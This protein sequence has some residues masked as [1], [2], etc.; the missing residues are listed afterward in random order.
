M[1]FARRQYLIGSITVLGSVVAAACDREEAPPPDATPPPPPRRA[2][3]TT[4]PTPRPGSVPIRV[5]YGLYTGLVFSEHSITMRGFDLQELKPQQELYRTTAFA[6]FQERYPD[7]HVTFETHH[8]PLPVLQAAHAADDAPDLFLA[9]DRR[10]RA[11]VRQG[12]AA[13]LDGRV[14]QW[15]DRADFVRPALAA[16]Q[17]DRQ[18]WGLPLFTQ[19]YTLYYNQALLRALGILRLPTTWEDLLAAAEQS[20]KVEGHHVVRQGINGPGPQWFMWLLQS[21]GATLYEAGQ[22]GFGGEAEAILLFLRHLHHAVHPAGVEPLH[23]ARMGQLIMY[24][25]HLWETGQLA[26]AWLPVLPRLTREE[27]GQHRSKVWDRINPEPLPNATPLPPT[28]RV[29]P[30]ELATAQALWDQAPPPEDI[31]IGRLPSP[32]KQYVIP[33]SRQVSPLIYTHSAVLHLSAQS[34]HPDPAWELLTLLLEPVTLHQYTA[35]RKAVPPRRSILGLGYL[36]NPKTQQVIDL[37]LR[38]GR[39]PF[40]PPD[41]GKVSGAI[42]KTFQD[43]V[44]WKQDLGKGVDGLITQL[45]R[46]AAEADPPYTGTTR[47]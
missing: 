18:Q 16:G 38:Y 31:A 26:H 27:A 3:I 40:D 2:P 46:I 9:D 28:L 43:T 17:Y 21:T 4:L 10:G 15:P 45:D 6:T 39:P 11:V 34:E 1:R 32:G 8:D 35:I 41:Y 12:L 24:T 14:R 33:G 7:N 29:N 22:A 30:G 47:A 36:D 20:T 5:L 19:V 37:W 25:K 44:I 13:R 23:D 42:G